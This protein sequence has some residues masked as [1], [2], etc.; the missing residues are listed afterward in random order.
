[1]LETF[2]CRLYTFRCRVLLYISVW[3]MRHCHEKLSCFFQ[4]CNLLSDKELEAL[5]AAAIRQR[6]ENKNV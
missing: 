4:A 6:K 5:S 1:M 3:C 2:L